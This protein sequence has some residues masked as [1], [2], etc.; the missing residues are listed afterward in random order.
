MNMKRIKIYFL[1]KRAARAYKRYHEIL[2]MYEC[3]AA[4]A[5]V[6]NKDLYPLKIK[7]NKDW[8]ELGK[9]DPNTPNPEFRL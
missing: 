5:E 8:E 1:K 4:M 6:I 9:L 7:F 2:D 3:G